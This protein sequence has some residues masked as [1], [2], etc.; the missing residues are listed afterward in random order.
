MDERWSKPDL[1]FLR[2]ALAQGMSFA[3]AAGFLCRDKK[4]VRRKATQLGLSRV[5]AAS[6]SAPPMVVPS[7]RPRFNRLFGDLRSR[8]ALREYFAALVLG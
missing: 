7:V 5:R 6:R 2:C 8:S 3:D 1:L 4:E